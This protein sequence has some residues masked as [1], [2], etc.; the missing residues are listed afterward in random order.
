MSAAAEVERREYLTIDEACELFGISKPT[1]YERA[2]AMKPALRKCKFGRAARYR[3]SEL[4][5]MAD[6]YERAMR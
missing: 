1:F 5:R 2:R 4:E 3:R 6:Y